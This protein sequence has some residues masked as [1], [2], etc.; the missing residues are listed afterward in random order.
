[1]AVVHFMQTQSAHVPAGGGDSCL[2]IEH[3]A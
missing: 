1:M 2:A 3:Q